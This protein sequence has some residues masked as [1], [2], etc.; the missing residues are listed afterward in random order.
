MSDW[1]PAFPGQ[2]PPFEAGHEKSLTTGAWSERRIAP[3]AVE[4]EH[5]YRS[6][7]FWRPDLDNPIFAASVTAWVRSEA[8]CELLWRWLAEHAEQGLDELLAEHATEE[9]DETSSKGHTRRM[10][11]G[12]RTASV[13]EQARK[14]QSIA[15]GH[16]ARLGLDPLSRAKLGKDLAITGAVAGQLDRLHS[17]GS[18]LVEQYGRPAL[19]VAETAAGE[20][21]TQADRDGAESAS[22]SDT[23]GS[24][25]DES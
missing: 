13:L 3:L 6:S 20:P 23:G 12:R 11:T 1:T 8:V 21:A 18:A 22:A 15:A 19:S 14:W 25:G 5:R 9:T 16:R 10:T 24:D 17:T 4:I 7:P 2:R